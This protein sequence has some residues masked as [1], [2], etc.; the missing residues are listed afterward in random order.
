MCHSWETSNCDAQR[1]EV[2]KAYS[3][4]DSRISRLVMLC[5]GEFNSGIVCELTKNKNSCGIESENYFVI[6]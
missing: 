5:N 1:H 6:I 2:G 4:R 3:W